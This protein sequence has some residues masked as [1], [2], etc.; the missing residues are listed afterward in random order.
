M[1]FVDG[2]SELCGRK[3]GQ[4]TSPKKTAMA[5]VSIAQLPSLPDIMVCDTIVTVGAASKGTAKAYFTEH[6]GTGTVTAPADNVP[7]THVLLPTLVMTV[8]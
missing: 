1:I 6:T 3:R 5:E 7:V 4:T 8:G 2:Q